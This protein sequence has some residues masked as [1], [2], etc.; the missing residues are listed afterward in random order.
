[1]TNNCLLNAE[2]LSLVR[3]GHT[4]LQDVSLDVQARDFITIIGPNGAGKTM[5]LKILMGL[6]APDSGKVE[7][8]NGLRI[9]YVPQRLIA[10]HAI[11]ITVKRFLSLGRKTAAKALGRIA[12]ITDTHAILSKPLYAL[13]G[14]EL[15]RTLLA[16]ALLSEPEL[17]ILDEPAQNLDI[18]GQLAFYKLLQQIYKNQSLSILMVSHDLHLVMASSKRVICLFHHI[19]CHGEPHA[20]AKDPA[21]ISLFGDDMARLMAIY[22][23]AH[24]HEH[25]LHHHHNGEPH[26]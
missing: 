2:H 17:L 22:N 7:K 11:P 10:D 5:L 23:H 20:V 8:K 25:A 24:D 19:C 9:G 26:A 3:D 14:G 6:I 18:A 21:F 4:I 13:S 12:E 1:M 16:R 15:Q